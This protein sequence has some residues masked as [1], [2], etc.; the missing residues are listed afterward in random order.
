MKRK[1]FKLG[2]TTLV[3]Y[4]PA[5]WI[6]QHNLKPGDE[7]LLFEKEKSITFS[8]M[9]DSEIKEIEIDIEEL[10]QE[11]IKEYLTGAFIR[12]YDQIKILFKKQESLV[13]TQETIN[14]LIGLAIIE[15]GTNYCVAGE[16]SETT[17]TQFD[18]IFRR[19][20][21][22]TI[23]M[24]EDSLIDLIKNDKESLKGIKRRDLDIDIFINFCFRILNKKGYKDYFKTPIVYNIL[25]V[26]K[27]LGNNYGDLTIDL[28]RHE[29]ITFRKELKELYRE[30]NESIRRF[31]HLFYNFEKNDFI[32]FQI[33]CKK[34]NDKIK[35]LNNL[36]NINP[37]EMTILYHLRKINDN[38]YNLFRLKINEQF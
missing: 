12:G 24:A 8:T 4:L 1:I 11:L 17:D 22:L 6:K 28:I 37:E 32:S 15:Q 13:F 25:Q 29:K 16:I 35:S 23:S 19:I 21:L 26:I 38:L 27:E 30:T 9:K 34:R 36:K 31:Y 10:N 18:N 2:A 5:K 14:S 3:T 7:L 20:F 33:E